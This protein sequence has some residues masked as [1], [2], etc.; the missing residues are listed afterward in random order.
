MFTVRAIVLLLTLAGGALVDY[1]DPLIGSGGGNGLGSYSSANVNPGAQLPFGLLRLGPDTTFL[2]DGVPVWVPNDHLAGY[3]YNDTHVI[4]F[5]HTHVQGAG[6]ADGGAFGVALAAVA[7]AD[8][9]AALIAGSDTPGD[10]PYRTRLEHGAGERAAPG[11][12]ALALPGVGP[13]AGVELIATGTHSGAHRYT[14]AAGGGAACVLLFDVCHVSHGGGCPAA[15]ASV[16][17]VAPDGR[18]ISIAASALDNGYFAS[19]GGGG[20]PVWVHAHF[21]VALVSGGSGEAAMSAGVWAARALIPGNA[22]APNETS[23]SAG[24]WVFTAPPPPASLPIVIEVRVGLSLVSP[25]G[26]AANLRADQSSGGGDNGWLSFDAL[27]VR[28][29]AAWEAA[30]SAVQ[31]GDD[32]VPPPP[33]PPRD[34]A[35]PACPPP[36]FDADYLSRLPAYVGGAP[37]LERQGLPPNATGEEIAALVWSLSCFAPPP[38]DAAGWRVVLYSALYRALCAPTTVSDADGRYIGLD[39]AVHAVTPPG[40]AAFSDLSLWDIHR[41]QAPL[42]TV[43]APNAS[44]ALAT[45]LLAMAAARGG[46]LPVWPY[47]SVETHIMCANHAIAVLAD[48][49]LKRVPGVDAAEAWAAAQSTLAARDAASEYASLGWI[50]I[51]ESHG[52]CRPASLT[53]EFAFDDAAAAALAG[54]AGETAAAAALSARAH[55]YANLW[56]PDA[57]AFCPRHA[58]GTRDCSPPAI[59]TPFPFSPMDFTEATAAQ[60]AWYVPGDVA[61]LASL[62]ATP[63]AYLAAYDAI[64]NATAAWPLGNFMPNPALWAGNEPSLLAPWEAAF[65]PPYGAARV[66]RATRALLAKYWT[67][68]FDGVPG[69]DDYGTMSAGA[70]WALLGLYP[71]V[72]TDVYIIGSP[73][74]TNT[75]VGTLRIIARNATGAA[76]G[77][78]VFVSSATLNGA[79]LATP[80]ARHADLFPPLPGALLEF[81]MTD[82]PVPWG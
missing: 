79:R 12:Y 43:I 28:G 69:N 25:D 61:G 46:V 31:I 1:V 15:N 47:A 29:T 44:A 63:A 77:Q 67:T 10:A 39:G 30:L 71:L 6:C 48:A 35:W 78:N 50:P 41:T 11:A 58:N 75:T 80:F 34:P 20:A 57:R 82:E 66:Q 51:E 8:G 5:S 2:R 56:S 60:M 70:V 32:G 37:F 55:N 33:P 18:N 23:G 74:F 16:V 17:A 7:D 14:C 26:A 22:T 9:V 38:L 40:S 72:G 64:L 68:R 13:G 54:A 76:G 49:V 45:S 21:E 36:V 19:Q 62:Y 3:N 42:L 4:A 59:S 81:V 52:W 24:V 53:L 65:A 27:R 73:S